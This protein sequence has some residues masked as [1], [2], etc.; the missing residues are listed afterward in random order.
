[1]SRLMMAALAAVATLASIVVPDVHGLVQLPVAGC[2]VAAAGATAWLTKSRVKKSLHEH[3]KMTRDE[4]AD[5]RSGVWGLMLPPT[6][7]R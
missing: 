5:R 4:Y 1:M 6:L 3:A 7:R 2:A